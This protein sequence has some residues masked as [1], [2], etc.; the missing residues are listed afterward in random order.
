MNALIIEVLDLRYVAISG[1][2]FLTYRVNKEQVSAGFVH[3]EGGVGSIAGNAIQK[4]AKT[5]KLNKPRYLGLTGDDMDRRR[6]GRGRSAGVVSDCIL[7][8]VTCAF[9][10]IFTRP[11]HLV[12]S[13]LE[14]T[15]LV[16][17]EGPK[18]CLLF[19]R[20]YK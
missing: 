4:S 17:I 16:A 1:N 12:F 8:N 20:I 3:K 10:G 2:W 18:G 6:S 7:R 14:A 9:S 13:P 15:G 11:M 19:L 5:P